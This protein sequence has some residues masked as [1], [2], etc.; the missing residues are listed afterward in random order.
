MQNIEAVV[1][2][3]EWQRLRR[4]VG[5]HPLDLLVNCVTWAVIGLLKLVARNDLVRPA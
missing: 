2:D 1:S 5:G 3:L 4:R